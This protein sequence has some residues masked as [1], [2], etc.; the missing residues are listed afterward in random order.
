VLRRGARRGSSARD[1]P[2]SEPTTKQ[3]SHA[4]CEDDGGFEAFLRLA[5]TVRPSGLPPGP[6]SPAV[7]SPPATP[8]GGD[9]GLFVPTALEVAID[10]TAASPDA[11]S[12][13]ATPPDGAPPRD[14]AS[15]PPTSPT[16]A[17][18]YG[19]PLAVGL[20]GL[21]RPTAQTD[22]TDQLGATR[23]CPEGKD[24]CREP[25]DRGRCRRCGLSR[26]R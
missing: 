20:A 18:P 16:M 2:D 22:A 11:S 19:G 12:A 10:V 4:G 1:A 9:P 14:A 3:P 26:R 17:Q 8:K 15:P 21:V 7:S 5:R 25:T 23:P 24:P 13:S 6:S